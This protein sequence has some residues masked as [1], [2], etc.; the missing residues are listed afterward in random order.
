M[1]SWLIKRIF[2]CLCLTLIVKISVKEEIPIKNTLITIQP[3]L[4]ILYKWCFNSY[5]LLKI[6][7]STLFSTFNFLFR[8]NLQLFFKFQRLHHLMLGN[9]CSKATLIYFNFQLKD[10][11]LF[12]SYFWINTNNTLTILWDLYNSC[13]LIMLVFQ[14]NFNFWEVYLVNFTLKCSKRLILLEN[15]PKVKQ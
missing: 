10:N 13:S 11:L 12:H 3:K 15:F 4:I 1:A 2:Y 14:T 6:L 5:F 8:N 7:S 9:F